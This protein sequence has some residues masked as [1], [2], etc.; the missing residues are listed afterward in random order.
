MNRSG[1]FQEGDLVARPLS[2]W[3]GLTIWLC[4]Q[5]PVIQSVDCSFYHDSWRRRL[6]HNP[7]AGRGFVGFAWI[8]GDETL[9]CLDPFGSDES[10]SDSVC[11]WRMSIWESFRERNN[12]VELV[13]TADLNEEWQMSRPLEASRLCPQAKDRLRWIAIAA[14]KYA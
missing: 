14:G 9:Q 12:E 2:W 8:V 3:F 1:Y 13:N 11:A 7:C 6:S 4:T 5:P 10:P